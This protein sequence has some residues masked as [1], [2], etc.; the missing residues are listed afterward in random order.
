[1]PGPKLL[2]EQIDSLVLQ[3]GRV[4]VR[5]AVEEHDHIAEY[6]VATTTGPMRI[7]AH[8][9]QAAEHLARCDGHKIHE[10]YHPKCNKC[11][12]LLSSDLFKGIYCSSTVADVTIGVNRCPKWR[13]RCDTHTSRPG[14]RSLKCE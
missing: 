7:A 10:K 5:K 8:S 3:Y 11:G 13:T 4:A 1:M 9:Q 14:I 6:E 2:Q 12:E